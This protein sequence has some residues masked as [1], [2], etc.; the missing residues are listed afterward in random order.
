VELC[1]EA[2]V[3][4]VVWS[5]LPNPSSLSEGELQVPHFSDKSF[6]DHKILELKFPYHS[7]LLIGFY[8]QNFSTFSKPL[9]E[10]MKNEEK[11][12]GEGERLVFRAGHLDAEDRLAAFD[13]DDTGGVVLAAFREPEKWGK[14]SY[15]SMTSELIPMRELV[16]T[17][18]EVT[19]KRNVV[20]RPL[21]V[22]GFERKIKDMWEFKKR[23][24]E[25][26]WGPH[27]DWTTGIQAFPQMKRWRDWLQTSAFDGQTE[28]TTTTTTT[29]TN[30]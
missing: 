9:L 10:V 23:N 3:E 1:K 2:N 21:D 25:H 13:V 26:P 15:L 29:T 16:E 22:S 4:H 30:M 6:V 18:Q 5:T 28:G 7:F 17:F 14:G 20:L 8:F 27:L 11:K 19:G 24:S 12:G